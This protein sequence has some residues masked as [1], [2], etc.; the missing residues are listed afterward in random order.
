MGFFKEFR[1]FAMRGNVVDLA[2]AVIIG[3]AFGKIVASLVADIVMPTVG[4]LV[5]GVDFTSLA[6]TVDKGL[7]GKGA[8]I[9]YGMFIQSVF[10]FIIVALAIFA[11]IQ[12]INRF[13]KKE[14]AAPVA[15]PPSEL[16][17][18]EI[19]DL[20]KAQNRTIAP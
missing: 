19:R 20:L 13:K 14:E 6:Y 18:T 11:A 1:D 8:T 5:G 2:V 10:D 12:L 3:G 7:G 4:L 16:L 15:T 9:K 17:L